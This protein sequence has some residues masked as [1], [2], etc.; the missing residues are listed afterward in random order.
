MQVTLT[1]CFKHVSFTFVHKSKHTEHMP[2]F[3]VLTIVLC[4]LVTVSFAE[5]DREPDFL[6]Q[7]NDAVK[8]SLDEKLSQGAISFYIYT[9]FFMNNTIPGI[10]LIGFKSKSFRKAGN[11]LRKSSVTS[12]S[13]A[14]TT[15]GFVYQNLYI[16]T[17]SN[18]DASCSSPTIVYGEAVNRCHVHENF[19]YKYQIAT[20]M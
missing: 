18:G 19:S 7:V 9:N 8:A 1:Q 5:L 15:S 20:G 17:T 4:T 14:Y 3:S 2:C 11:S 13:N 6:A 16:G 10:V 12:F